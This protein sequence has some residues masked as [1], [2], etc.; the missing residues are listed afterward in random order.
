MYKSPKGG[1]TIYSPFRGL[2][3]HEWGGINKKD[4]AVG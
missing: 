1:A 4:L 2:G 3:G